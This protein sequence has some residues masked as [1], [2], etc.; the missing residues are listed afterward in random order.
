MKDYT[1]FLPVEKA[2]ETVIGDH[3]NYIADSEEGCIQAYSYTLENGKTTDEIKVDSETGVLSV[4]TFK[5]RKTSYTLNIQIV[6]T[7]A[8]LPVNSEI[9]GIEVKVVCGPDSITAVPPR[10][11]VFS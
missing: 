8:P 5:K 4:D 10:I 7:E 6:T 9:T 1:L 11:P 2:T 3:L